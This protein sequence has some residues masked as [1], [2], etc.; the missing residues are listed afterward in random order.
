MKAV[1][2]RHYGPPEDLRLCDLPIP[3]ARES[4]LLVRVHAV[5]L[6][7]G[8][9]FTVRGRPFL[10]RMETG[11]RRPKRGIPGYDFSGVVEE[12]GKAVANFDVGD[13]VYGYCPGSCAEFVSVAQDKL[14]AKPEGLSHIEA[15]AIPT[16]ALAALHALR[17]VAKLQSGQ[18]L[19]INGASGGVGTFAVQIA[20]Y[21]E[22]N[23]TA[24]CSERNANLVRSL[25]ADAVIDYTKEDFTYS[26]QK[27][28]C[29]F[30][31]VENRRLREVRRVLKPTGTLICNSGT[32]ASGLAF[33]YRLLKPLIISPFT[34][35]RLCRYLSLPNRKDLEVL[36][37]MVRDGKLKPILSEVHALD[38]VAEALQELE[39]GHTVGKR[40]V[41]VLEA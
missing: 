25:E 20:K 6:H 21:F 41:R 40:V 33:W 1:S 39:L 30:D 10:V 9:C 15:A 37:Q 35:Q 19:L 4:E 18:S 26:K 23:V 7:V 3:K 24:V 28:D 2:A 12:I 36:N 17:D 5:G 16:S 14:A 31:N 29:I 34:K 27:Y 38:A 32:G 13:E 11:W 22:A 8:D